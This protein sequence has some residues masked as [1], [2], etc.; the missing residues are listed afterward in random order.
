MRA[1]IIGE[2]VSYKLARPTADTCPYDI[3]EL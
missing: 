1:K 2:T 3:G